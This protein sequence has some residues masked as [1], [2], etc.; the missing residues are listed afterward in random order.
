MQKTVVVSI[1][2]RNIHPLYKKIIKRD[3]KIKAD[4]GS[5]RPAIGDKIKIVEARPISASK[6]F[7]IL[8]VIKDGSA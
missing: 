7:K 6:H 2:K 5:F 4:I 3:K 8:E 1:V